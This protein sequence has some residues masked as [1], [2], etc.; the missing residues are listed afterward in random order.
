[1]ALVAAAL[2]AIFVLPSPWGVVAVA[3]GAFVEIAEAWLFI[4]L[5]RRR[6]VRVGIEALV[7]ATAQVVVPCYP[8]GQVRVHGELWR[9]RCDAGADVGETVRITGLEG[10]TLLVEAAAPGGS[11]AAATG[12]APPRRAPEASP[13]PAPR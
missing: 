11:G 8:T 2:L 9:A 12:S 7:G 10:L 1:M 6:R 13:P 4:R 3:A 5:S